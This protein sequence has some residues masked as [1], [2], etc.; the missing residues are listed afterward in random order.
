MTTSKLGLPIVTGNMSTDVVRDV[1]A[2]AN[3]V[4]A[5]VGVAGGLATLDANG[6]VIGVDTSAL[7]TKAEVSAHKTEVATLADKGH[8]QLSNATNSADESMAA[9]P[10][11][12][13]AAYDL[14]NGKQAALPVENRRKIT[15]GTADPTGGVDGDIYFQYE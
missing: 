6:K 2:L 13:K 14:A 8:V 7:A 5:K 15:F 12:V 3:A 4:D 10:K 11:A 1:N 9:T